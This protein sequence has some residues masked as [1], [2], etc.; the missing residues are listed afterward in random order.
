MS[1]FYYVP[2][3][4][5]PRSGLWS[6]TKECQGVYMYRE[7]KQGVKCMKVSHGVLHGTFIHFTPYSCRNL[8]I[9]LAKKKVI[10]CTEAVVLITVI[11]SFCIKCT[12]VLEKHY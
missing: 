3:F 11:A 6:R 9:G 2:S 7:N 12:C 4:Y 8:G 1:V 5:S 10:C